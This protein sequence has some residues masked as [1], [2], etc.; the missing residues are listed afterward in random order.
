MAIMVTT[1]V[2][3]KASPNRRTAPAK[4]AAR[5]SKALWL[6]CF[7]E[8]RYSG[9]DMA[10]VARMIDP[11]ITRTRS[12]S[13]MRV[14]HPFSRATF[15]PAVLMCCGLLAVSGRP[16]AADGATGRE[17]I[18]DPAF[19]LGFSVL[20]LPAGGGEIGR[21]QPTGTLLQP[22]W[23]LAQWHS[24]FV[25]THFA[26]PDTGSLCVS[27]VA[28]RLCLER[29]PSQDPILTLHLDS[30]PEY[31]DHLRRSLSQPWV[32][33]LVQQEIRDAPTLADLTG[34]R[35]RF[36]AR[37]REAETFRPDGYT[38]S[39]HAAQFQVVLTLNN[40]RRES[41]G[42]GDYL[43]FVVPIYDDRYATPPEYIARDFAVTRGK[44][45]YNPGAEALGLPPARVG[46]WLT[47]DID[48]RPWLE[49]ALDTAWN[50]G[51][52]RD[53]RDPADYRLAH[54][55]LGWEVPGLNR[56]TMDLRGLSLRASTR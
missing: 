10:I 11:E 44:L 54:L 17:L 48:L 14:Q 37:L 34:L 43:W 13:K 9:R 12:L 36:Q 8:K 1:E 3:T 25:L 50:Q 18:R 15:R 27:N 33:L 21:I 23:Q 39:L 31:Q 6:S 30:R 47:A 40:T 49:R 28:K 29:S 56:V 4:P 5:A 46:E 41:P 42:Y 52:L 20:A 38:P 7:A 24:R 51:Y 53:S 55:N 2:A 32:H 22:V 45:I 35:L 16:V 26:A 19:D